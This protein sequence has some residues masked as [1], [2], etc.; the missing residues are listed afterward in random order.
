[1][2]KLDLGDLHTHLKKNYDAE[3][4]KENKQIAI[5]LKV[6]DRE[7]PL[8]VGILHE[9]LVQMIAYLP[10]EMKKEASGEVARFLHHL[11]KELDLPGFGMDENAGLLFYRVVIP[12]LKPEV[13]PDLV[14]AYIDTLKRAVQ[15]VLEGID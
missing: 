11:N 1:M 13:D 5:M 2:L 3:L 10:Y 7:V 14:N 9:A 4:Q 12:C 8:F 6:S 15:S